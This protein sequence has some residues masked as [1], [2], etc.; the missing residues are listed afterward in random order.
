MSSE[1]P[2]SRSMSWRRVALPIGLLAV[3]GGL[4]W[5]IVASDWIQTVYRD[6]QDQTYR[7]RQ[8]S[9]REVLWSPPQVLGPQEG[10]GPTDDEVDAGE[11]EGDAVQA[12]P[13]LLAP[14][15]FATASRVVARRSSIGDF[16][17]WLIERTADG[18]GE[19][20]PLTEPE[21]KGVNSPAN[22][23]SPWLAPNGRLLYFASDREGGFG[24]YDLW[25]SM[26]EGGGWTSPQNLGSR[27][28]SP[29]DET[30]ATL[31]P[32]GQL[33]VFA[34]DRPIGFLYAPPPDWISIELET[35]KAAD[36]NLAWAGRRVTRSG[37]LRWNDAQPLEAVTTAAAETS[38]AFSDD[39]SRLFFASDREGGL[40]G[41]DLY[42]TPR[43]LE[44]DADFTVTATSL[45]V[46]ETENV[47]APINSEGDELDPGLVDGGFTMV[48]EYRPVGFDRGAY[49]YSTTREVQSE[50]EIGSLPLQAFAAQFGRLFLLAVSAVGLV[51]LTWLFWRTRSRWS[52][53]ALMGAAVVALLIHA[54]LL[55]GFYFWR[56]GS[57][58]FALARDTRPE[59]ISL[60]TSIAHVLNQEIRKVDIEVT[61]PE[62][63]V[64]QIERLVP[65]TDVT[66]K[67][68]SFEDPGLKQLDIGVRPTEASPANLAAV[69]QR[70]LTKSEIPTGQRSELEAVER[71]TDAPRRD[72]SARESVELPQVARA[73]QSAEPQVEPTVSRAAP[74][75]VETETETPDVGERVLERTVDS[76]QELGSSSAVELATTPVHAP[77]SSDQLLPTRAATATDR[78]PT[79]I[80]ALPVPA[81]SPTQETPDP[82]VELAVRNATATAPAQAPALGVKAPSARATQAADL[83]LEVGKWESLPV[84]LEPSEPTSAEEIFPETPLL[85]EARPGRIASTKRRLPE[86]APRAARTEVAA[87]DARGTGSD[88]VRAVSSQSDVPRAVSAALRAPT[89]SVEA[90][91]VSAKTS[92]PIAA[93][94]ASVVRLGPRPTPG[95]LSP[96]NRRVRQPRLSSSRLSMPEGSATETGDITSPGAR[97][98][99]ESSEQRFVEPEIARLTAT[100]R[101]V[102]SGENGPPAVGPG[103][104]GP[105]AD[106][107]DVDRVGAGESATSAKG[108]L[109]PLERSGPNRGGAAAL[110]GKAVEIA[111]ASRERVRPTVRKLKLPEAKQ[112]VDKEEKDLR[113]VRNEVHRL[114]IVQKGGGTRESEDAV[115]NALQW[116]S[117]N[118]SANGRWDVDHSKSRGFQVQCDAA[119]TGLVILAFLGQNHTPGSK[120]PFAKKVERA[121]AWMISQQKKDGSLAGPDRRYTMYTHGI[122]T[123]AL[124]EAY[125][126]TRNEEYLEPLQRACQLIL[127]AQNKTTGGWRYQPWP[128]LRGD[129]SITGWQ[130][131]ALKSA[132]GGGLNV[133]PAVFDRARHWLDVEVGG[134]SH[135]GLYGY[136]TKQDFRVAMVAEGLFTR[137]VLGARRGNKSI[138][139][140]ARYLN[141]ETEG[142]QNLE[143]LYLLYYG[144][145]ALYQY[146]GWIWEAWNEQV[147]GFLV[148]SQRKQGELAGSW[149]ADGPW[150]EAGGRFLST[151][152]GALTL[153]VYYRYLPLYWSPGGESR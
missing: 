133:P 26:L 87:G 112:A 69:R 103:R 48:F 148:S 71:P 22:E 111:R 46:G 105:L 61:E 8:I 32:D 2:R 151:A 47:G 51:L 88:P 153:E 86:P 24:G 58:I 115:R 39:G 152:L 18:W 59:P 37:R 138:E 49:V 12:E 14:S 136:S 113:V 19:P 35:W 85:P 100:Q 124:S 144:T 116:L 121:L 38:P 28:N 135:G 73:E 98:L 21:A 70:P 84:G 4:V 99:A 10:P 67:L 92:E 31:T 94:G 23:T 45:S 107:V 79:R 34:T 118:Q 80:A 77:D 68:D 119:V 11:G 128:P 1:T 140:A 91:P 114:E 101:R 127:D 96:T 16:D 93:P 72:E 102:R 83:V 125:L 108:E 147:R 81:Q 5:W 142:G 20:R 53:S 54:G 63:P 74:T 41:F 123:L 52:V 44:G 57:E 76:P 17:L 137:Q 117:E 139:E 134:G 82:S 66:R 78:R 132:S 122:A 149:D 130:V 64:A 42:R 13:R 126:M 7:G 33:L 15:A 43:L 62:R 89:A 110:E 75:K 29:Y 97:A 120:S 50:V 40:G 90:R 131:M 109:S 25:F 27:V 36:L 95:L 30:E 146:Q 106:A 6:A 56:V 145:M 129:T 55:Y 143:N 3:L 141:T 150:C 104:P 65:S 9:V 60:E